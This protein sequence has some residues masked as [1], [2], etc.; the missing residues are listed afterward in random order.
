MTPES[1]NRLAG[2]VYFLLLF[3][4]VAWRAYVLK[5]MWGWFVVPLGVP[6]IT[7]PIAYG[8]TLV[9]SMFRP[10]SYPDD[11]TPEEARFREKRALFFG[12]IS[13]AVVLALGWLGTQFM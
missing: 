12:V 3:P 9:V 8:L 5:I 11:E 7:V 13:P 6:A 1:K 2:C 10:S 4:L